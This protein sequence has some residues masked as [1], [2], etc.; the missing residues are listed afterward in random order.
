MVD[1]ARTPL[2]GG[3]EMV[4][5]NCGGVNGAKTPLLGGRAMVQDYSIARQCE[6]TKTTGRRWYRKIT[7]GRASGGEKTTSGS[8]QWCGRTTAG[9]VGDGTG[10]YGGMGSRWL[11][12]VLGS[13]VR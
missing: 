11:M 4:Q 2:L 5:E 13:A 6:N 10:S 1:G 8:W 7:A 12:R 3:R 9:Q